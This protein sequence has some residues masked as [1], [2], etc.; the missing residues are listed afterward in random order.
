MKKLR[1]SKK[2]SVIVLSGLLISG[3]VFGENTG[4][5]G[6]GTNSPFQTDNTEFSQSLSETTDD[7]F[8]TDVSAG[9]LGGRMP[10]LFQTIE[11]EISE[12][13][14]TPSVSSETNQFSVSLSE[15]TDGGMTI[16]SSFNL[17]DDETVYSEDTRISY[18]FTDG[19]KLELINAGNESGSH[20]VSIP[21]HS[22]LGDTS[23][24]SDD[25]RGISMEDGGPALGVEWHTAA[26]FMAD[27]LEKSISHG[28]D[29]GNPGTD[30]TDSHH[31]IG[32]TYVTGLG[33]TAV[34]VGMAQQDDSSAADVVGYHIG[35]SAVTGDLTVAVGYA[36]GE[37][38][39][40]ERSDS[41]VAEAGV[42]YVTGDLTFNVGVQSDSDNVGVQSDSDTT[43]VMEA[44][45]VDTTSAS[46]SYPVASG[47]TAILGYTDV[48]NEN[49]TD[50]DSD[51]G[52]AWYIG[53]NMSF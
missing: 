19:S 48:D 32:A 24:S 4:R 6:V 38:V 53:A 27:G 40:Q 31:A 39:G 47:V 1:S 5:S 26:D 8:A 11:T 3:Y 52:S 10:N 15:T 51:D 23:K 12:I 36:D 33:D 37:A 42:K 7:F 29:P 49:T 20:N 46:V 18:D 17:M 44:E 45:S 28:S 25:N 50:D 16:S 41:D 30:R 9:G 35:V 43:N 2:T 14:D 21:G 34:T 22:G 13:S